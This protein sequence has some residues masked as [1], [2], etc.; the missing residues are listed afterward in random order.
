MIRI[1]RRWSKEWFP[2]KLH[3]QPIDKTFPVIGRGI[4][5]SGHPIS[6]LFFPPSASFL[7]PLSD[8]TPKIQALARQSQEDLE[9]A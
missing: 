9:G 7:G 1:R 6:L 4:P 5:R 3:A 8:K 2:G